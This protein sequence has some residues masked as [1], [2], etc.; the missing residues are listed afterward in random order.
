[1]KRINIIIAATATILAGCSNAD[2]LNTINEEK[3]ALITFD[4]YHSTGTKAPIYSETSLTKDNNGGFGV[5]AF[6]HA[7]AKNI[8]DGKIDLSGVSDD[9]AVF[10]NTQT[11][12]NPNYIETTSPFFTKYEYE[13]PRYWDKQMN[14]TFFAYAPYTQKA[15]T[16]VRGVSLDK[17]TG[18]ITR[19]DIHKIQTASSATN[20][21][22][23]SG[24][25]AKTRAKYNVSDAD[26]IDYLLAPCVPGQ[27]WHATN[28][29]NETY[30]NSEITVGFIFHHILSQLNVSIN[31][32]NEENDPD[33]D[34]KNGHEYKGIKDIYVSKLEITN[35][36]AL[37]DLSSNYITCQQNK[38]DF[39][40]IYNTATETPL[41]FTPGNY[42][43]NLEI[44]KSIAG[45][46]ATDP[47]TYSI[48]GEE[49]TTK[50]LYILDGG[51]TLD[52]KAA[53]ST[54][55][56][57]YIDQKF[58]FFVAPNKPSV[59]GETHKHDLNIDYY[60]EYLD[61]KA[62]KFSR[63]IQLDD[64]TFNFDEMLASYIYN[65]NITISLDQIYI[66]VDD[67]L[68]NSGPNTPADVNVNGD[69]L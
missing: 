4:T 10:D 28:Q 42:S 20:V 12:Y 9:Y 61:N 43:E 15:A 50:P 57:G 46:T 68:W 56:N 30:D 3:P 23:G 26:V 1:M 40:A 47:T 36:P 41:T 22:I 11:W 49:A 53:G 64:A 59:S 39:A 2:I 14:Y 55:I 65:I 34:T 29:T 7:D 31:A 62:E 67:V 24:D 38:I 37:T 25:N 35:L 21:T 54:E 27:K 16:G 17:S 33:D 58:Q 5:F 63:T 6:K 69:E 48:N 51:T 18:K 60:I 45:A 66:T 32:K 19:D 8:S 44:V 52:A 13:Y